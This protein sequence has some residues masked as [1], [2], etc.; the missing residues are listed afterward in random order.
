MC[1]GTPP[2]HAVDAAAALHLLHAG[3]LAGLIGQVEPLGH[4]AVERAAGQVEPR[5]GLGDVLG[6]RGEAD[7]VTAGERLAG[8]VHQEIEDD[9]HRRTLP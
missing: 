9:E 1:N 6:G 7:V 4:D 8:G 2:H 5:A 3:A